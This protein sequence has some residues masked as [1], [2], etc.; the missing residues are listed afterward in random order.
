MIKDVVKEVLR[1]DSNGIKIHVFRFQQSLDDSRLLFW[2]PFI[3]LEEEWPH[4]FFLKLGE[5]KLV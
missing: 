5:D 1:K 4:I 3:A 2:R